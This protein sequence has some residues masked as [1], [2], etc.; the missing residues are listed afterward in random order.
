[1]RRIETAKERE[2]QTITVEYIISVWWRARPTWRLSRPLYVAHRLY[3]HIGL[4]GLRGRVRNGTEGCSGPFCL[5]RMSST[6]PKSASSQPTASPPMASRP[7]LPSASGTF[8]HPTGSGHGGTPD[9]GAANN[10]TAA[11]SSTSP[12]CEPMAHAA[13]T[14]GGC[15]TRARRGDAGGSPLSALVSSPAEP[16]AGPICSVPGSAHAEIILPARP[17]DSM[18][19]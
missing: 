14:G 1:M 10:F 6:L 4:R 12:V 16:V 3:A 8:V 9:K 19:V 15:R 11:A 2:T 18:C 5:S 13:A 7:S 17:A